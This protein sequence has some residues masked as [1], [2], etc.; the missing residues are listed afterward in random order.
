[1]MRKEI[2]EFVMG[3]TDD[4]DPQN[5]IY[6]F[7]IYLIGYK[8]GMVHRTVE[9]LMEKTEWIRR[10][11]WHEAKARLRVRGRCREGKHGV[12]WSGIS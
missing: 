8:K 11:S 3:T 1:M 5:H 2:L 9:S 10:I 12:G 7:K 4:R 6:K